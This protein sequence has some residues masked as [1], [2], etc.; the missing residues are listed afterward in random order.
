MKRR[1]FEPII[2]ALLLVIITIIAAAA[3]YLW[4]S[5]LMSGAGTGASKFAFQIEAY[6]VV[7][8]GTAI[9]VKAQLKNTGNSPITITGV[10]IRDLTAGTTWF[11][12]TKST[13]IGTLA[14]GFTVVEDTYTLRPGEVVDVSVIIAFGE[15]NWASQVKSG[16]KFEILFVFSDGTTYSIIVQTRGYPLS[17]SNAAAAITDADGDGNND[18]LEVSIDLTNTASFDLIAKKAYIRS[19]TSDKVTKFFEA[20]MTE[21][22]ISAGSTQTVTA[23]IRDYSTTMGI[24]LASNDKVEAIIILDTGIAYGFVASIP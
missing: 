4:S 12:A 3:I 20:T 6:D 17:G 8:A 14:S 2:A 23:Y 11:D 21:T 1:G 24:T 15:A 19:I 7:H 22:T 10:K 16:D 13:L 9:T 18:D 5:G